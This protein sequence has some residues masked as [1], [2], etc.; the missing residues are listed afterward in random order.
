MAKQLFEIKDFSSG[1]MTNAD[2]KDL[3]DGASAESHGLSPNSGYGVAESIYDNSIIMDNVPAITSMV[4]RPGLELDSPSDLAVNIDR[5]LINIP[6][7]R[8]DTGLSE[9]YR[10]LEKGELI[11]NGDFSEPEEI[12][13]QFHTNAPIMTLQN[14]T[15]DS[16]AQGGLNYIRLRN[17]LNSNWI[18]MTAY[19]K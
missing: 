10:I 11:P 19:Q 5:Y 17:T 3:P 7:Y 14:E 16:E 12:S 4:V 6:G 13:S 15:F 2:L 8:S 1:L 9:F 18:V